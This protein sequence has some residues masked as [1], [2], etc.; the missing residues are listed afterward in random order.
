MGESI[1]WGQQLLFPLANSILVWLSQ[2]IEAR[3]WLETVLQVSAGGG[4]SMWPMA[5]ERAADQGVN[6]LE[7]LR[8]GFDLLLH[9]D[10]EMKKIV[11]Q[12]GVWAHLIL[13]GV[14]FC[15]TGLVVTPFLPGDSL[16]FAAGAFAADRSLRIEWLIP[17]LIIAA[18][19]GDTVNYWLGHWIG[20][21]AF[22]GKVPFLK[23]AHL[24]K[25]HR[26][27]EKYGGKTIILARFVPIVRTFAPFV[28]GMGSMNYRLFLLYNVVGG[29]A[30]VLIFV[31]LGYWFGTWPFI[32]KNFELVMVAI[33]G[34]SLAPPAW[35]LGLHW[36]Q[37][38][39]KQPK[40]VD[41]VPADPL[42]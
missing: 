26:F 42:V 39:K 38:R 32:Q 12:Y 13:F 25:T 40:P 5:Q 22:N 37:K 41:Q 7:I 28:A 8:W 27:F 6:L 31:L 21:H 30:W 2:L 36:L 9:L 19:V 3:G 20:E 10:D 33:V 15:E 17:L 16:L 34:L 18:I 4:Y 29:I 24:E 14:I 1:N 11:M 23:Q 35:E